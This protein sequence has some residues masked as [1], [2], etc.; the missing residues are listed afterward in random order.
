MLSGRVGCPN[1]ERGDFAFGGVC[2]GVGH[3]DRLRLGLGLAGRGRLL[4]DDGEL[5]VF[6]DA[7]GEVVGLLQLLHAVDVGMPRGKV[8]V[9]YGTYVTPGQLPDLRTGSGERYVLINDAVNKSILILPS[10]TLIRIL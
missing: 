5:A 6:R 2:L 4:R 8:L 10:G 3:G 7:L 9:T 1:L